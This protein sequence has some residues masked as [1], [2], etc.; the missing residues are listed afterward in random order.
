[1]LNSVRYIAARPTA[2][3]VPGVVQVANDLKE[4]VNDAAESAGDFLSRLPQLVSRLLIAGA[5]LIV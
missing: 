3:P 4:T 5:V 2:T 1:M